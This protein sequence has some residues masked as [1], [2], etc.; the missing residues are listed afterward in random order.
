MTT[1]VRN[2]NIRQAGWSAV[3]QSLRKWAGLKS[4]ALPA[5]GAQPKPSRTLRLPRVGSFDG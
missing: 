5:A 1:V 2:N 4:L 3:P